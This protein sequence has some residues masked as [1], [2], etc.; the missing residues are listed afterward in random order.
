MINEKDMNSRSDNHTLRR[1]LCIVLTFIILLFIFTSALLASR[2]VE[3]AGREERPVLL[4]AGKNAEIEIFKISYQNGQG[5]VVVLSAGND[6]VVAP[7]T[8]NRTFIYLK[9]AD[10]TAIDYTLVPKATFTSEYKIPV[11]VRLLRPDGNY[12]VGTSDTWA[13]IEALAHIPTK[14]DTLAKGQEVVYT[15]EWK[16]QY[17]TNAEGDSYDTFLGDNTVKENIGI[18]LSF[19]TQASANTSIAANGGFAKSGTLLNVVFGILWIL[20]LI[21]LVL[22]IIAL[23]KGRNKKGPDTSVPP[24]PVPES[25]PVS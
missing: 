9:N 7:G 18:E 4:E 14:S 16:W 8:E 25:A 13:D 6:N 22:L 12:I 17:E 11:L 21:A 3:L 20:L 10:T 24:P 23:V 19:V 5:K 15:L 2:L 1:T